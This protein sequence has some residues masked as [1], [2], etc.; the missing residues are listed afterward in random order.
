MA[1]ACATVSFNE[2]TV[3]KEIFPQP[4]RDLTAARK[5]LA[6]DIHDA[7]TAFSKRVFAQGALPGEDQ[8]VDRRRRG[9][10][11]PVPI[12]TGALDREPDARR[13]SGHKTR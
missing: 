8:A 10:H 13:P 11:H 2:E 12:L 9:A 3:P 4:T 5:K 6:P 7:F 1:D